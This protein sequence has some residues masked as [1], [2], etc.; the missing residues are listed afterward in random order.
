MLYFILSK[1]KWASVESRSQIKLTEDLHRLSSNAP[2]YASELWPVRFLQCTSFIHPL[3]CNKR[4]INIYYLLECLEK[5]ILVSSQKKNLY[6]FSMINLLVFSL[7]CT[8][9][10]EV[11]S[12]FSCGLFIN[13]AICTKPDLVRKGL[14]CCNVLSSIVEPDTLFSL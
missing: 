12:L 3:C 10:L 1:S 9:S 7:N 13:L 14:L 6:L 5:K 2:H 11:R 8:L 4:I